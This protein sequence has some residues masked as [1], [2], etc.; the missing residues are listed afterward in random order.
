MNCSSS[1]KTISSSHSSSYSYHHS[2]HSYTSSSSST[3]H[4]SCSSSS[5]ANRARCDG[6][7][8]H[9]TSSS[10]LQV[11]GH[12]DSTGTQGTFRTAISF[13]SFLLSGF[14]FFSGFSFS[15]F[16]FLV[17]VIFWP[18]VLSVEP[19]VQYVVCLSICL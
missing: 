15:G 1:S 6:M 17:L 13:Y 12:A 8:G 10:R 4:S 18:T 11:A 5:A 16:Y 2:S 14:L 7:L 9:C 3:S 19:M